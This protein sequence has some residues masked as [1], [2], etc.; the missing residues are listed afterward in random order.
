MFRSL[1]TRRMPKPFAILIAALLVLYFVPFNA[2]PAHAVGGFEDHDGNLVS[3][4]GIDWA[5]V[6]A[7]P[8]FSHQNDTTC[9]GSTDDTIFGTGSQ[10][11]DDLTYNLG[12]GSVPPNKNDLRR[13]Y[14]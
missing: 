3:N 8:G 7:L 2:L 6:A 4:G 12:C 1:T 11:N 10:K 9:T 14:A 5:S 13:A